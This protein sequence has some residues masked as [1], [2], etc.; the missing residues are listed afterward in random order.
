MCPSSGHPIQG[1]QGSAHSLSLLL[2]LGASRRPRLQEL[3]LGSCPASST[4]PQEASPAPW[5]GDGPA[6]PVGTLSTA[7]ESVTG[8]RSPDPPDPGKA[9]RASLSH[10]PLPRGRGR[11][12][13]W[14]GAGS[15]RPVFLC[16]L[17]W[18]PGACPG[19][20]GPP[21][22]FVRNDCEGSKW[23][24][25]HHMRFI[26]QHARA[27]DARLG[28]TLQH[29]VLHCLA[30]LYPCPAAPDRQDPEALTLGPWSRPFRSLCFNCVRAE[31]L[32]SC[33]T[34][35]DPMDLSPPG[36]PVPGILQQ[37][38]WSGLPSLLQE[39]FLIQ[40]LIPHLLS[41]ALAISLGP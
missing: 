24:S 6:V 21:G 27:S 29:R 39:I 20:A 40:G 30:F 16:P 34:L 28:V 5:V 7:R 36:S 26:L 10:E 19:Q 15:V 25:S 14:D 13:R 12:C 3:L 38:Y 4:R 23:R 22:H 41:L 18:P 9:V 11:A 37:E 32:Q 2:T 33:P 1:C 35:C 31:E 17:T 8:P